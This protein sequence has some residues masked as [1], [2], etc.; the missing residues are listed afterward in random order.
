MG[1]EHPVDAGPRRIAGTHPGV[2]LGDELAAFADP[3]VQAL[4]AKHADFDLNQVEPAG[5]LSQLACFGV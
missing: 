3:P 5:R 2:D 4:A 1:V